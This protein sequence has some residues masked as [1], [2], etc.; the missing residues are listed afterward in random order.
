MLKFRTMVDGADT[1][2]EHLLAVNEGAGGM[3]FKMRQDPRVT[4]IGRILRRYSIDELPQF[5]NVL[6]GDMSVV[7]PR[8][9]CAA[10]STTTTARS[11]GACW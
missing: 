1:Q 7:G 11:R 9:R 5:I 4:P 8:P 2:L 3:L 6:K 10:K